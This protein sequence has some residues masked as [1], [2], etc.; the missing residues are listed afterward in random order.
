MNK[1]CLELLD[2]A[3]NSP[4][5]VRF[6]DLQKL[7]LCSGMQHDRTNGSHHVYRHLNPACT[8]TIQKFSDGK[9]KPYQVKQIIDFIETNDLN[10]EG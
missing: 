2:F 7:C 9:A 4:K 10:R 1:R 3:R 5:N 8:I 6:S